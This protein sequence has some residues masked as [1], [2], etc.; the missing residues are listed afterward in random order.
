MLRHH[1]VTEA[2]LTVSPREEMAHMW[3]I[4]VPKVA[5]S[6]QYLMHEILAYSA[7]HLAH[8]QQD[9]AKAFYGL[10]IHHQDLAIRSVRKFLPKMSAETAGPLAVTSAVL[11]LSVFA[12]RNMDAANSSMEGKP[13]Q[14]VFEDLLDIF[15]LIQGIISILLTGAASITQGPFGALISDPHTISPYPPVFDQLQSH[16]S[17]L[18]TFLES[19]DLSPDVMAQLS[20]VITGMGEMLGLAMSRS[21]DS[22]ELRFVFGCV[23]KFA[24]SFL[25]ML[26]QR[27]DAALAIIATYAVGVKA[28]EP[29]YWFMNGWAERVI[30]AVGETIDPS[31]QPVIQ[32]P[33]DYIISPPQ[34][35]SQNE[36]L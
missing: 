36:L 11:T 26:R 5:I 32:W 17:Y 27:E 22:K 34:N 2:H 14:P 23:I 29:L 6:Q 10:G 3:R 25:D 12:S 13:P 24:P 33:W 19:K 16:L 15:S 4:T 18:R 30:R 8:L 21:S 31:W 7:F 9:R 35:A 20:N 1:W 28:T